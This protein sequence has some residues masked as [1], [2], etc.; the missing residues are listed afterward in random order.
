MYRSL[1]SVEVYSQITVDNITRSICTSKNYCTIKLVVH[2]DLTTIKTKHTLNLWSVTLKPPWWY[3]D[4]HYIS[5]KLSVLVFNGLIIV[6]V[7][8]SRLKDYL[9]SL[10]SIHILRPCEDSDICLLFQS[11]DLTATERV[12]YFWSILY[13]WARCFNIFSIKHIIYTIYMSI[14]GW[15]FF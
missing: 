1:E 8:L 4:L 10:S 11:Q 15:I 12:N 5:L 13:L 2:T 9:L 14:N 6:A 7:S 3:C